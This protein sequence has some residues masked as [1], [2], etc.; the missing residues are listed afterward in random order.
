MTFL[1]FRRD[2]RVRRTRTSRDLRPAVEGCERRQLLSTGAGVASSLDTL[3]KHVSQV[4]TPEVQGAHIG[5][6]VAEVQGAH[7]GSNVAEV[8]GAHIGSNVAEIKHGWHVDQGTTP[9]I[10][11]GNGPI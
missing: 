5:S 8:Q 1:G 11:H 2:I 10:K 6:N 9:E 4:A 7:I 3:R